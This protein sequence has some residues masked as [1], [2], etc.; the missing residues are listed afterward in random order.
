MDISIIFMKNCLKTA[1]GLNKT[2]HLTVFF[3]DFEQQKLVHSSQTEK[4]VGNC[5]Q[6]NYQG[7]R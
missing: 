2:Q 5:L 6:G 3:R 7:Q 4:C 1:C